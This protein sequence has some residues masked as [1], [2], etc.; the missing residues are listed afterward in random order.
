MSVLVIILSNFLICSIVFLPFVKLSFQ[1]INEGEQER[2][3]LK[4]RVRQ[5]EEELSQSVPRTMADQTA[6]QMANITAKYRSL[7][8]DQALV[9]NLASYSFNFFKNGVIASKFLV[10]I[11]DFVNLPVFIRMRDREGD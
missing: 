11:I 10:F 6:A 3:V 2:G 4:H 1:I 9:V 7:L 8:Q 5:L